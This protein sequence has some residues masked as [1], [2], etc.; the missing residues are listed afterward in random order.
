MAVLL[1]HFVNLRKNGRVGLKPGDALWQ[2]IVLEGVQMCN[3][4]AWPLPIG[5][6]H[7]R[8]IFNLG[9]ANKIFYYS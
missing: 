2:G 1:Y 3:C 8:L 4:K 6:L 9:K 5:N 7:V